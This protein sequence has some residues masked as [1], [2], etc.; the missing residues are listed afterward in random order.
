MW[1]RKRKETCHRSVRKTRK[2]PRT[3][4]E[5]EREKKE[6]LNISLFFRFIYNQSLLISLSLL[7][8]SFFFINIDIPIVTNTF[9][10][11]YAIQRRIINICC[12][13]PILSSN[14]ILSSE[15]EDLQQYIILINIYKSFKP[16]SYID[17]FIQ[18]IVLFSK[19]WRYHFYFSLF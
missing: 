6:R 3:E 15:W 17:I 1:Y 16:C 9:I 5:R 13:S 4:K 14:Q 2:L 18:S 19:Q 8:T 12:F 7:L 10:S 11:N